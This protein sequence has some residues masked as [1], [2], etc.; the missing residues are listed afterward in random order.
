ME[1]LP[2]NK[3]YN[4]ELVK[5]LKC[6]CGTSIPY[7]MNSIMSLFDMNYIECPYCNNCH[8]IDIEEFK[9]EKND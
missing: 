3:I 7:R 9:I 5:H 8:S 6:Q 4:F 1:N 2:I